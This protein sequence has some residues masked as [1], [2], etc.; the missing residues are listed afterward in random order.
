LY[1]SFLHAYFFSM[2]LFDAIIDANHRALAGDNKAGLH[3]ADFASELPLVALTCIDPRL[4]RFFPGVLGLPEEQFIWLRNAGNV[5][6]SPVSSS[7]RS[8]ALACAIKGGREIAIIGHTDCA[9]RKTTVSHLTECLKAVGVERQQLPQ[10]LVQYFGLFASE[11]QNVICGVDFVRQSP[12]IG[13]KIPVHGLLVETDSGKLQWVVNGYE[14]LERPAAHASPSVFTQC[15]DIG[16]WGNRTV[17]EM[18]YLK[19]PETQIGQTAA[20]IGQILSSIELAPA[21]A[22][23]PPPPSVPVGNPILQPVAAPTRPVVPPSRPPI[24]VPPPIPA[25]PRSRGRS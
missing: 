21:P 13:P 19:L 24:P 10:N 22:Q 11:R 5:I 14:A 8:L 2:R 23:Q 17:M 16:E 9:V 12:L 7:M 15:D 18:E 3:V 6:S 1:I 4:N 20:K 25:I